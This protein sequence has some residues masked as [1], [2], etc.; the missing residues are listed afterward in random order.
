M[1]DLHARNG[2][3]VHSL[4]KSG[5][6]RD[7][8]LLLGGDVLD[9]DEHRGL[10]QPEVRAY[11][12][13]HRVGSAEDHQ[14]LRHAL[15]QGAAHD[16]R[17]RLVDEDRLPDRFHFRGGLLGRG[18]RDDSAS[19]DEKTVVDDVVD[20]VLAGDPYGTR[21]LAGTRRSDESNDRNM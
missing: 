2:D 13:E 12:A 1:L 10:V 3:G 7:A 16:G 18:S 19:V 11:L 5:A 15:D 21:A 9:P 20:V 17:S 8:A 4:R 6:P 14:C